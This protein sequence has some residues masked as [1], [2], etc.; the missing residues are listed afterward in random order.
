LRARELADRL[1]WPLPPWVEV[2]GTARLLRAFSASRR[3]DGKVIMFESDGAGPLGHMLAVYIDARHRG[4][5]KQLRLLRPVD[6][7]DPGNQFAGK[8]A[9]LTFRAADLSAMC[10]KTREAI[11][12]TDAAVH[13][14]V[15]NSFSDYRALALARLDPLDR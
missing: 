15:D 8:S 7:L 4:I 12:R 9:S 14:P 10:E 3:G 11:I 5:A 2:V 13:P 6:P 1:S